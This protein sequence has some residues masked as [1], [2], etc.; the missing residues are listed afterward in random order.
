MSTRA[1][2]SDGDKVA[3]QVV[4]EQQVLTEDKILALVSAAIK[5]IVADFDAKNCH[6]QEGSE[7]CVFP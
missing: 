6:H 4:G 5:P 3:D 2:A 1:R 7:D